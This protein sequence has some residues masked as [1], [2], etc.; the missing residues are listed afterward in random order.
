MGS[1][2]AVSGGH[3]LVAGLGFLIVVA[4]LVTVFPGGT[5]VKNLPASAGA[6]RDVAS[7]PVSG[8]SPGTGNSNPFQCSCLENSRDRGAWWTIVR[9]VAESRTRP[10]T[11]QPQ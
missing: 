9:R 4:S 8:R 1:L 6:A 11:T 3:S 2:V 7:I 10:S 5:V